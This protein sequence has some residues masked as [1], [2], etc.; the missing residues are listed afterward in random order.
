[1]QDLKQ[2]IKFNY[3]YRDAGNYKSYG[4]VVFSNKNCLKTEEVNS[5]ITFCLISGEFFIPSKWK[6]PLI[7]IFP[8]D[9]DLDH[10]WYEFEYCEYSLDQFTDLR[11]IDEFLNEIG[12]G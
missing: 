6:I 2:N 9:N 1:M 5:K 12:L 11:T 10:E 4:S 7:Y 3:L 8:Y